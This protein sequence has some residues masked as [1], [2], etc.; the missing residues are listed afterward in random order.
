LRGAAGASAAATKLFRART[1]RGRLGPKKASTCRYPSLPGRMRAKR[2]PSNRACSK[3]E[4][5]PRAQAGPP[6]PGG[7]AP[8]CRDPSAP[9]VD[10][11]PGLVELLAEAGRPAMTC[12]ASSR[13]GP[14][15]SRSTLRWGPQLLQGLA[16]SSGEELAGR[17]CPVS[18]APLFL[19]ASVRS[20]CR[21]PI[22]SN[23]TELASYAPVA[24]ARAL[25]GLGPRALPRRRG[26][27]R[28]RPGQ[29]RSWLTS[30][31]CSS[32]RWWPTALRLK[33]GCTT[34]VLSR[35]RWAGSLI[36]DAVLEA[37]PALHG[38][39]LRR[40]RARTGAETRH[41]QL[42]DLL[43]ALDEQDLAV[44]VSDWTKQSSGITL[45]E[46]RVVIGGGRGVG[47]ADGFRPDRRARGSARRGRRSVAAVRAPAGART[48][49]QVARP[50]RASAPD[51]TWP[52]GSAGAIQPWRAARAQARDSPS[53]PTR[54]RT[55]ISRPTT[56]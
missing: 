23:R 13:N 51:L 14:A 31:P 53:T 19:R 25:A 29:R 16:E 41:D 40:R 55:I 50:A 20:G 26:R 24:W 21:R 5:G 32:S 10:A 30:V 47:S 9:V 12:F 43:P 11:V 45:A 3:M 18:R 17:C 38:P 42:A 33:V 56:R 6:G 49:H 44:R 36:E 35:Q 7:G 39:S 1:A 2:P 27:R 15:P 28:H 4:R 46:A 54:T 34:V 48:L 52:V 22:R 8:A 37:S